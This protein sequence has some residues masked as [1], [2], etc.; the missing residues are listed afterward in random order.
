MSNFV[1]DTLDKVQ[2]KI[3]MLQSLTDIEIATKI[4][5]KTKKSKEKDDLIGQ[6]YKNLKCKMSPLDNNVN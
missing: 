1:I 2:S 5:D 4:I 3:D 6:Y